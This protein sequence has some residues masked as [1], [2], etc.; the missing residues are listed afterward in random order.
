[1]REPHAPVDRLRFERLSLPQE[2]DAVAPTLR[3]VA[4]AR[5]AGQVRV[6]YLDGGSVDLQSPREEHFHR[7]DFT[8][9]GRYLMA[10]RNQ[11]FHVES[12]DW[13]AFPETGHTS[14]SHAFLLG[15]RVALAQGS[16]QVEVID[17]ENG[18][19]LQPLCPVPEALG[20]RVYLS[21]SGSSDQ[22]RLGITLDDTLHLYD[23]DSSR[24]EGAWQLEQPLIGLTFSPGGRWLTLLAIQSGHTKRG[25]ELIKTGRP[26]KI[27]FW[28]RVTR[29]IAARADCERQYCF[30]PVHPLMAVGTQEGVVDILAMDWSL[31]REGK[32][33]FKRIACIEEAGPVQ[34]L[35]FIAHGNFLAVTTSAGVGLWKVVLPESTRFF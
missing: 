11:A 12:G 23:D 5:G 22:L 7:L 24:W 3:C 19:R 31:L 16:G 1:M 15:D 20:R 33:E 10:N 27:L 6:T 4:Q 25:S 2:V 14:N 13:A 21:V 32:A 18:E 29:R 8:P 17:L 30:S 28:D 35:E 9:D 34:R 26:A